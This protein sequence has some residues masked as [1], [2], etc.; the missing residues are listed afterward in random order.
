MLLLPNVQLVM[1]RD[2]VNGSAIVDT[3]LALEQPLIFV[4]MNYRY[5]RVCCA[6]L[7]MKLLT[8]RQALRSVLVCTLSSPYS[9]QAIALGFLAGKEVR[10]AGVGN[11]G[12]QD[13]MLA[14]IFL[15]RP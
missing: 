1:V 3:S 2:R 15:D 13:R 6:Q 9:N 11:L 4:S 14:S 5:V 10:D 8:V 12:L 7:N